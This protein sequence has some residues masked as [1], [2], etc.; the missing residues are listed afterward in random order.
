MDGGRQT[1]TLTAG[2]QNRVFPETYLS[3]EELA[4]KLHVTIGTLA[5]WRSAAIGPAF[6]KVGKRKILYGLTDVED[7]MAAN[8]Q[9]P[10]A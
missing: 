8:R 6:V 2:G 4:K 7:Y 9:C 10:A 5:N 1:L 3:P